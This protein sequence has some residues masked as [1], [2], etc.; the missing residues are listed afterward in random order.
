MGSSSSDEE[1]AKSSS[2][3]ESESDEE[4]APKDKT[5]KSYSKDNDDKSI[6][7]IKS[8]MRKGKY[9]AVNEAALSVTQRSCD[10]DSSIGSSSESEFFDDDATSERKFDRDHSHFLRTADLGMTQGIYVL[11]ISLHILTLVF[12]F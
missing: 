4:P 6:S 2:S 3:S 7:S 5:R 11:L 10:E 1:Y 8:G 9:A 12:I